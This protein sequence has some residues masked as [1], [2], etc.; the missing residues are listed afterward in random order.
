MLCTENC[1]ILGT[2]LTNDLPAVNDVVISMCLKRELKHS[3][4]LRNQGLGFYFQFITFFDLA[5]LSRY[6]CWERAVRSSALR[7]NKSGKSKSE[8]NKQSNL[9]IKPRCRSQQRHLSSCCEREQCEEDAER[10]GRQ[11]AVRRGPAQAGRPGLFILLILCIVT[12]PCL[13]SHYWQFKN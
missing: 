9:E 4:E 8:I 13:I 10:K 3:E 5:L 6:S 2:V 11:C 12:P 7:H 1:C